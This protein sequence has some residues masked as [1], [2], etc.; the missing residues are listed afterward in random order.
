MESLSGK[1]VTGTRALLDLPNV[2]YW[3]ADQF[4]NPVQ[5]AKWIEIAWK[6]ALAIVFGFVVEWFMRLLLAGPRS[7]LESRELGRLLDSSLNPA[8]ANHPGYRANRRVCC[9]KLRCSFNN[10]PRHN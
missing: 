9:G 8:G 7:H 1:I 6:V 10:G 4:S 3:A 5:R 2:Y